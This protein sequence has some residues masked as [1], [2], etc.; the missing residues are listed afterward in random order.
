MNPR[1][2]FTR[3]LAQEQSYSGLNMGW[4]YWIY[5]IQ[6]TPNKHRHRIRWQIKLSAH[7]R[8]S[9]WSPGWSFLATRYLNT[10]SELD[11]NVDIT[12]HLDDL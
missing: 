11:T 6:A 9:S 10:E 12:G 4:K 3:S 5:T 7:A 2:I 1:Y 8:V